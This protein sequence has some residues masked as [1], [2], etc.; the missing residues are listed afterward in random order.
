MQVSDADSKA[1]VSNTEASDEVSTGAAASPRSSGESAQIP[2]LDN[3]G[4]G[5][6]RQSKVDTAALLAELE[7][8]NRIHSQGK[9]S[10]ASTLGLLLLIV[11]VGGA[12]GWFVYQ[13]WLVQQEYETSLSQLEQENAQ[14]REQLAQA[15][16]AMSEAA[17]VQLAR[18]D[19]NEALLQ[20]AMTDIQENTDADS[21]RLEEIRT[22]VNQDI[23][24]A[25]SEL[26]E[27]VQDIITRVS[28]LQGQMSDLQH[29]DL[30]WLNNEASY[31]MRLAQ[32]KL[33]LEADVAS[34]MLLLQTVEELLSRQTSPLATSAIASVQQDIGRL[35]A[36][37]LP[38]RVGI[39]ERLNELSRDLDA[40]PLSSSPQR[41]YAESVQQRMSQTEVN[42][43]SWWA[44]AM[45]LIRAVFVWRET[46]PDGT[47]SLMPDQALLI[48]QQ[49]LL[50]LEQARLAVVQADEGMY[51]VTLDQLQTIMDRYLIQDNPM[52]AQLLSDLAALRD[53]EITTTLPS[54]AESANRVRQ[55]AADSATSGGEVSP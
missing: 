8:K 37:R 22:A 11:L 36:L 20:Q 32:R 2:P 40:L 12:G 4:S 38:D 13:Q 52:A 41:D 19:E 45:E 51:E 14:I 15:R 1:G 53:V 50:Q 55:L 30:A 24:G 5:A 43:D 31:L 48:K 18:L 9:R 34:A 28:A 25:T 47:V 42:A 46:A 3:Q 17:D 7:K 23:E 33:T 27:E 39:A 10:L 49:L 29:R 6:R 26:A 54:L 44:A 35:A 21:R 16:A